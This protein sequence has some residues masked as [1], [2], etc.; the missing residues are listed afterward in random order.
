MHQEQFKIKSLYISEELVETIKQHQKNT[1]SN[2][3]SNTAIRLICKGIEQ[4]IKE[5]KYYE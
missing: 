3:F 4:E 1:Y 5:S 2:S